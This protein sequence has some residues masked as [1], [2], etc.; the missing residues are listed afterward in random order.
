VGHAASGEAILNQNQ[1]LKKQV[2]RQV[3]RMKKAEQDEL[4]WLSDTTFIGTLGL[5]FIL[6]IMA[7]AY[8]GAWLDESLEGY[9]VHWTIGLLFLGAV[10]GAMNVYFLVRK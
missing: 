2:E 4:R 1:R 10:I 5:V 3:K 8:L 9:S 7:G 6:P